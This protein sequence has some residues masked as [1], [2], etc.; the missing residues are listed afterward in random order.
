MTKKIACI[1]NFCSFFTLI[2]APKTQAPVVSLLIYCLILDMEE[3]LKY[4]CA[5]HINKKANIATAVLKC[6]LTCISSFL[7]LFFFFNSM[8]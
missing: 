6:T 1:R 3:Q 4:K 2:L 5:T 7:L 8:Y